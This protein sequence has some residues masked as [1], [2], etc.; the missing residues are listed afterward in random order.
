M[1]TSDLK[2]GNPEVRL[3]DRFTGF[4][5]FVRA[6]VNQVLRSHN[7]DQPTSTVDHWNAVDAMGKQ[8][9]RDV[10]NRSFRL[11]GYRIGR[12]EILDQ[13]GRSPMLEDG[14]AHAVVLHRSVLPSEA[15]QPRSGPHA[16]S[17]RR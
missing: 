15:E 8:Q 11:N 12:H 9:S 1:C 17:P 4:E 14:L 10:L 7:A 3:P 6:P 13:H 2:K 5:P 16:D